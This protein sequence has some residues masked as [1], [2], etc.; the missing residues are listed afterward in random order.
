MEKFVEK[1][2]KI[3]VG[4]GLKPGVLMGPLTPKT[5]AKKSKNRSK[6]RSNA[7]AKSSSVRSDPKVTTYDK[8]YTYSQLW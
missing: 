1:A 7:A 4:N 5:S 8:G 6:M 2:Q 3:S